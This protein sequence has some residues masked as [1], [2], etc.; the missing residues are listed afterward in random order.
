M[1]KVD[2]STG[3][4][5]HYETAGTG[6]PVL[7]IIGTGG[8]HTF[9]AGQVGAYGDAYEVITFD[10]RG[11]GQSDSPTDRESY[12]MR[13]LSE[14]AAALLDTLEVDRA[15]VAGLSLGATVAQELAI[16]HPDRVASL[17]L[18]CAWA[19]SDAWLQ[20][21]FETL[22]YPLEHGDVDAFVHADFVWV[23][24]P[25]FLEEKPDE[26]EAIERAYIAENP[27]PPTIHG[28]LGQLHADMTHDAID[29]LGTIDAP[30]LITTGELD[31]MIPVRY[32]REVQSRIAG[33]HL[34]VFEGPGSSHLA[35]IEMADE[36]NTVTRAFLDD[37]PAIPP[38]T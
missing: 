37:Q 20:R 6:P 34:H 3:V 14:D 13:I 36:F 18:H 33:S 30:T 27:H 15:H 38:R 23:A 21:L 12:S 16:N 29:R 22:V 25:G 2:L 8:D 26:V 28:L 32:G 1:P 4:S 9:W 17:Q 19:R 11:A 5:I 24:S 35:F 31:W 7:M 10:N